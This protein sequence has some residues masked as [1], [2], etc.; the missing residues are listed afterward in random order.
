MRKI[1]LMFLLLVSVSLFGCNVSINTT[2]TA[3]STTETITTA[4]TTT[5]TVPTTTTTIN[6]T[7]TSPYDST[8]YASA[9][10]LTGDQLKN[11]LHSIIETH[12]EY[13]YTTQLWSILAVTD[14]D[15]NNPNNVI[16]IYTG[17][18]ISA[19]SHG[20]DAGEWN[21]EHVWPQSHGG[22]NTNPGPG[23]DLFNLHPSDVKTNS[24][25]GNLD[26]DDGGTQAVIN[27]PTC[28]MDSDSFDPNPDS[29]GDIAR[30]MLYMAVC[31][32]ADNGI[33]LELNNLVNNGSNPFL[34][35]L[36]VLLEWN[37]ED[38]VSSFEIN[39]NNVIYDQY[40]HNRNPFIDHPEWA[41]L[42]WGTPSN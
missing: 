5:T 26:F 13:S 14:K 36:S 7:T 4:A 40:Q 41:D 42:I 23:T 24:A 16:E 10:T 8:Y 28:K 33:D 1:G 19:Q 18:S 38:P 15:P 32:E 37:D 21:R 20:G 39:R 35:K 34:G 12:T 31:Y 11:A 27:C 6:T 30:S 25:R 9:L 3:L 17:D 22:I 2:T 29:R